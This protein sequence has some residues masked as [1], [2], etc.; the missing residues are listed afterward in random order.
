M[1]G[2]I[3]AE[4]RVMMWLER[5]DKGTRRGLAAVQRVLA[6]LYAIACS[7]ATMSLR[8]PMG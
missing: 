8:D 7:E 4:R 5:R 2:D 3:V 1:T 6:L